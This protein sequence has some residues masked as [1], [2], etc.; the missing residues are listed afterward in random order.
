MIDIDEV[1]AMNDQ[2]KIRFLGV[3]LGVCFISIVGLGYAIWDLKTDIK[4]ESTSF[5]S[6][7]QA[8][9]VPR[10]K[11]WDPWRDP[12]DSSGHFSNMQKQMDEMMS[13][14]MPGKSIF[15]QH[16]FGLSTSSP[17]ITMK[18]TKSAYEIDVSVPKGQ[19]IEVNTKLEDGVLTISGK[20]NTTSENSAHGLF[21]KSLSTTQFSQSLTLPEPIDETAMAVENEDGYMKIRIPKAGS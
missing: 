17:E 10:S 18:E 4:E 12:W 1:T 20:V 9:P 3:L 16:G 15:T 2:I 19:E 6:S 14:M 8:L 5:Q 11:D 13:L 7:S 21:G